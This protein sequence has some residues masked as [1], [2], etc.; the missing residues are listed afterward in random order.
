M[1]QE[2]PEIQPSM[3]LLST[4][5]VQLIK[6]KNPAY[7]QSGLTTRAHSR[8]RG[9]STPRRLLDEPCGFSEASGTPL[10][11]MI[12]EARR[13]KAQQKHRDTLLADILQTRLECS[14]E[15]ETEVVKPHGYT[16]YEA[17]LP[18]LEAPQSTMSCCQIETCMQSQECTSAS[19][20]NAVVCSLL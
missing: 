2:L 16:A 4:N 7:A 17:S 20:W 1:R 15:L 11:Q 12:E 10:K 13:R 14:S 8:L 9:E 5:R 19:T 18:E 3:E 6:S